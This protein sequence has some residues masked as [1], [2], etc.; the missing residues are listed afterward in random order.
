[1]PELLLVSV[2]VYCIT[3][4]QAALFHLGSWPP[5]FLP[6]SIA[7]LLQLQV[8]SLDDV[9]PPSPPSPPADSC[10]CVQYKT[11]L[12]N[13]IPVNGCVCACVGL[14]VRFS[15]FLVLCYF[16][17]RMDPWQVLSDP[18]KRE[19]YD[20]LGETGMLMMEDPFA[21]K[22]VRDAMQRNPTASFHSHSNRFA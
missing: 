6:R 21:A 4:R 20:Q 22:D 3:I 2:G 15:F 13:P 16:S 1:M 7:Q 12:R 5:S 19:L 9:L 14:C 17:V 8:G 10:L 11:V 18:Q